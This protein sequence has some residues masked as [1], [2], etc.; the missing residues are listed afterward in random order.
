MTIFDL[1][2]FWFHIAPTWY[3][4]MYVLG[5]LAGY[6]ILKKRK[7][8]PGELLDTFL[9]YIFAGVILGGRL[10]YVFFYDFSYFIAHPID[11]LKTWQWWMAFHGGVIGVILAMFLFA[12]KYKMNF[13]SIADHVTSILP[14]GLWLGRIWN[15]L[16]K[17]LLWMPYNGPLAIMAKNGKT[18]FP[19]TLLEAI[20]E[21]PVLWIILYFFMKYKKTNGQVGWA[22]LLFYGI[23]RFCVEFVRTPDI[24][25]GYLLFG[26]VTMGQILSIPMILV[27]LYFAFLRKNKV[28]APRR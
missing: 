15:Y 26:W 24:Q 19:S 28:L 22:F 12:R 13:Y 17:E 21:W 23:I 8:F 4:L 27:W 25:L 7:V 16:N 9:M 14:I 20:F 6:M 2:L 18:Y 1:N 5:F 10:G 11:I 3:G